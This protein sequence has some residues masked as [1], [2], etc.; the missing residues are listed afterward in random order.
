MPASLPNQLT[1]SS[2]TAQ[3][4][5]RRMKH[6]NLR[7][8]GHEA[9]L[10]ISAPL[11][12]SLQRIHDFA[13]SKLGWIIKHQ[14][15]IRNMRIVA[16]V[17]NPNEIMLWGNAHPIVEVEGRGASRVTLVNGEVQLFLRP[18]SAPGKRSALLHAWQHKV[19]MMAVRELL[20]K[21]EAIMGVEVAHVT[22]QRMRTRWGSCTASRRR[23]CLN[24]E[25]LSRPPQYLEYVLVH[26]LCHFFERGHG[27][28]FKA[29]MDR[30][31]PDWRKLRAEL[32]G[33]YE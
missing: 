15:R 12:M 14:T 2:I 28:K 22:L 4:T 9:E 19:L 20:N 31:L 23:I 1:I 29:V 11:R 10:R 30:F 6:I 16:P 21:W 3:V 32:N 18:H 17:K 25:L 5:R 27:P 33:K 7:I 26:E 8:V 24:M 13:L